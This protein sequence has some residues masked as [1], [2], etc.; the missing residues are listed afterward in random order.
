MTDVPRTHPR[1]ESLMTRARIEEGVK[2]GLVA[3]QGLIAHGRGEA[4]DYLLGEATIP[5]AAEAE[6]AA[7]AHLLLARNPVL[8][9]NG[10]TAVLVPDELAALQKALRCKVEVN[11][12]HRTEARVEKLTAWLEKHGCTNVLGRGAQPTIPG[13]DHDR[14]R[15]TIEGIFSADV[16]LVPLEDGDRCQA[17][18]AMG[19]TVIV[20]DLNPLSRTA[21]SASVSITDNVRR[22]VPAITREVGVLSKS[23]AQKVAASFDAARNLRE[24]LDFIARRLTTLSG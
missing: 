7:A 16:V 12:F 15:S 23:E 3:T 5:P 8:S 20:V 13:L 24:T 22:A 19:K 1:Y 9:V 17:L 2:E 6:R 18:R 21:K 14:G 4:F 11:L 10:N